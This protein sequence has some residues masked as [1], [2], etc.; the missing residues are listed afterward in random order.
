METTLYFALSSSFQF[1]NSLVYISSLFTCGPWFSSTH[2]K[3]IVKKNHAKIL[4]IV[5]YVHAI[6]SE[7]V[8]NKHEE[9][10]TTQSSKSKLEPGNIDEKMS[11]NPQ[12]L[13]DGKPIN[14]NETVYKSN[15]TESCTCT[16][17]KTD[18]PE[19]N[20][21]PTQ[22]PFGLF[23]KD[24]HNESPMCIVLKDRPGTDDCCFMVVC[25]KT[26][27]ESTVQKSAKVDNGFFERSQKLRLDSVGSSDKNGSIILNSIDNNIGKSFGNDSSTFGNNSS[28][29]RHGNV[30]ID[31][32]KESEIVY[33]KPSDVEIFNV[34]EPV[35]PIG[36]S[37]IQPRIASFQ[38]S[39]I[40]NDLEVVLNTNTEKPDTDNSTNSQ[41]DMNLI[42]VETDSLFN[43]SAVETESPVTLSGIETQSP[44]TTESPV[45]LSELDTDSSVTSTEKETESS[46]SLGVTAVPET[47]V[48]NEVNLI[49]TLSNS[50]LTYN[51][52][53]T[54]PSA[55]NQSEQF[56]NPKKGMFSS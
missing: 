54:P 22:C 21:V 20:C 29:A 1:N 45:T 6:E 41:L 37:E 42:E 34:S 13:D 44:V 31:G 47:R 32:L 11:I 55:T 15:C 51:T 12:C 56:R 14:I 2:C 19:F 40:L 16:M 8:Q 10:S 5:P 27:D 18:Q 43:L 25:A 52:T 49:D 50:N 30:S 39:Q 28:E 36:Q 9:N 48:D 53:N 4:P 38:F 33:I 26:V 46:I 7:E 24:Q 23:R 3:K 35:T 17:T